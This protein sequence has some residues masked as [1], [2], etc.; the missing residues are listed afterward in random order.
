MVGPG[1]GPLA[2]VD[3]AACADEA[4]DVAGTRD[5][6]GSETGDEDNGVV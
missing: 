5:L 2:P 3:A 1:T 6:V 4:G